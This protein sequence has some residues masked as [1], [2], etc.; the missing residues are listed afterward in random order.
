MSHALGV[1]LLCSSPALLADTIILSNGERIQGTVVSETPTEVQVRRTFGTGKIQYVTPIKRSTIAR[2][3]KGGDEPA[4]EPPVS[5]PASRPAEVGPKPIADK[6]AF[7]RS[8][9]AKW[10]DGQFS[11]AGADLSR[12]INASTPA[13]LGQFSKEVDKTVQMSL[14][15]L[16][17]DAH[18][19]GGTDKRKSQPIRLTNITTYET[20][21]LVVFLIQDYEAALKEEVTVKPAVR[22]AAAKDKSKP[23]HSRRRAESQPAAAAAP[24]HGAAELA[25]PA[26]ADADAAP[27][28]TAAATG[29]GLTIANW[30]DRPTEFD[31]DK[32][33]A[34]ALLGHLHYT[35]SLL[36]ERIRLDP[37]VRKDRTLKTTLAGEQRRLT[38]LTKAVGS[39][40][41]GVAARAERN[42]KAEEEDDDKAELRRQLLNKQR[43]EQENYVERTLRLAQEQQNQQNQ[44]KQPQPPPQQPP[45]N[46]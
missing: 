39:H 4:A 35:N 13:E 22:A 7:L 40:V 17:A 10:Q 45:P 12:L 8:A 27:A 37:A 15:D 25:G 26:V 24:R 3:E 42:G 43:R 28:D 16:T 19:S 34:A 30:I 32:L 21:S 44:Q 20:P 23:A 36:A 31:A 9:I 14:A 5:S 18:L 29:Q 41:T 11:A 33:E 38:A 46:K 2:I 1:L 6:P